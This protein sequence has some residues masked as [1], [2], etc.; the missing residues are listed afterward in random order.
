[1]RGGTWVLN[2][3]E[4]RTYRK[5]E[6]KYSITVYSGVESFTLSSY[7]LFN[8]ETYQKSCVGT[9]YTNFQFIFA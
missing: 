4:F 2:F 7:M 9:Q 5:L 3:G 6:L 8:M 1:M